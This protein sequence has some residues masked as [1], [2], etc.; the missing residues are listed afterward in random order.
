MDDDPKN[1]TPKPVGKFFVAGWILAVVAALVATGGLVLARELWIG[2]QASELEQEAQ[3]GPRVLVTRVTRAP[4]RREIQLPAAIHGYI[5]TPLY[6]KVAGYLK[7]I[8]VDKGD[9]V[10]KD[11][12]VAI[13]ESPEIDQQVKNAR[14]NFELTAVTDRRNQQLKKEGV[15]SQQTVDEAHAAMLQAKA[16]LE[17]SLATQSYE[18][19]R[20][21]FDGMVTA[22][23]ADPGMLIPETIT[24]S[25]GAMPIVAMA[26]LSPLRIYVEAPQS[27]APFIR[28][29][30]QATTTVP[31]Y[32]E[33]EFKGTITRHP[34]ALTDATRTM[35]VE[36][37]LP[38]EDRALY[39][40]MYATVAFVVSVPTSAPLVPDDALVFRDG[41]VFV[42]VVRG[43]QL[44]LA[45]VTL[46]YDDG[47]VVEVTRGLG[48][49]DLVALNVGQSARDGE[50]VQPV[51]AKPQ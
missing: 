19:I 36:V 18:I 39:P 51:E 40:G 27:L 48:N 22:R 24:P 26:T 49:D 20:A 10:K 9:R 44:H 45:E 50:G 23:Y 4:S 32:P 29:G 34:D 2:R 25:N 16:T 30:D 5:E 1:Y 41:K 33:R 37:D 11:Q 31:E 38:N 46:G 15:V 21:P 8:K 6:A 47:Q 17:Q 28:N 7:I 3:T 42:P 12:V 35:R 13:L 14:A 43:R